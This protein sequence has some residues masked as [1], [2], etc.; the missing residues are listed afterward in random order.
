MADPMTL[1]LVG[2]GAGA[3]MSPRD[4][5]KGAILG[6]V[7][8][9][10]GGTAFGAGAAGSGAATGTAGGLAGGTGAT[11][12]QVTSLSGAG[13][14]GL[15]LKAAAST[16]PSATANFAASTATPFGASVGGAA[17]GSGLYTTSAMANSSIAADMAAKEAALKQADTMKKLQYGQKAMS[18]F[19]QQQPQPTAMSPQQMKRGQVNSAAP[20]AGLLGSVG[21][22][23]IERRRRM[24]LL[25]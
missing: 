3:I 8:G 24:S 21:P 23:D 19:N 14:S 10:A 7:G 16:L 25:G 13:G 9:Y 2:A 17:G 11:I 4:P 1:A 22:M 20:I 18:M 5:L 6:A 12:P 15:Q